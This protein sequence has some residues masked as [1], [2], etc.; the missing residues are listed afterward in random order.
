NAAKFRAVGEER[1]VVHVQR[2]EDPLVHKSFEQLTGNNFDNPAESGNAWTAVGPLR[3][4]NKIQGL[5]GSERH[6][7][8][9]RVVEGARDVGNFR[10]ALRS[11]TR[12]GCGS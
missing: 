9:E 4:R 7:F 1:S 3:A 6:G 10:R 12:G 5:F 2:F 11:D 8:G